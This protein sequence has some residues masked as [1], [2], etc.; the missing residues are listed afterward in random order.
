[1]D[2]HGDAGQDLLA[3]GSTVTRPGFLTADEGLTDLHHAG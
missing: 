1:L 3:P 2:L